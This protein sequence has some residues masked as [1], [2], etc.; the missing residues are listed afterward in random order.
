VPSQ[1]QLRQAE[2]ERL[3]SIQQERCAICKRPRMV[4]RLAQDHCHTSGK[5][6]GL[7]CDACN[8]GLGMFEDDIARLAAAIAYLD[9]WR[10]D[11]V[12]GGGVLYA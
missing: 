3:A 4:K 8:T 10:R 5:T 1:R 9:A 7:L 6:R 11:H 12:L 2:Y